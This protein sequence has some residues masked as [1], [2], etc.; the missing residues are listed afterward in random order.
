MGKDY[1]YY[2]F[3]EEKEIHRKRI[4]GKKEIPWN[5]F[6]LEIHKG[7]VVSPFNTKE[8]ILLFDTGKIEL[9]PSSVVNKK[10]FTNNYNLKVYKEIYKANVIKAIDEINKTSLEKVVVAQKFTIP[11]KLDSLALFHK[12]CTQYPHGFIYCIFI[13]GSYWLGASPEML[14]RYEGGIGQTVALAGTQDKRG[15]EWG[16]KEKEEQAIIQMYIEEEFSSIAN[17]EFEKGNTR[18][19]R[20]GAIEH[21][22][23]IYKFKTNYDGLNKLVKKLHPTPAVCGHPKQDAK[24]FIYLNEDFNRE[25]YSGFLGFNELGSANL[26]VNLRCSKIGEREMN[27]FAGAGITK[28]SN[29]EKEWEE[30]LKKAGTILNV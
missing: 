19:I 26:F 9:V 13:N 14:C 7:F 28:D 22:S 23:S 27:L 20:A 25:Y 4:L 17:F 11:I 21:I 1:I 16:K 6:D 5:E 2:R 18:T 3:P 30:I 24:D 12:M 29:P 8:S 15:S 10:I